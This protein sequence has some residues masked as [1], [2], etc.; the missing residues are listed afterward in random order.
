MILRLGSYHIAALALLMLFVL[1]SSV[2]IH[3]KR[4][5]NDSVVPHGVASTL[6]LLLV[7]GRFG[8]VLLTYSTF[9][10]LPAVI[11]VGVLVS[12]I[13]AEFAHR[14]QSSTHI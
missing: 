9:G 14:S 8:T 11:W 12:L 2:S 7:I 3:N 5:V 4:S 1:V 6:D 10:V 13:S